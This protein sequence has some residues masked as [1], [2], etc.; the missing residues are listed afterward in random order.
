MTTT[1]TSSTDLPE[2]QK[3]HTKTWKPTTAGVL[4]IIAGALNVIVGIVLAVVG[5]AASWY[6]MGLGAAIGIPL[7]VLA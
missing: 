7:I 1:L 2:L 5:A 3:S 4:T 6:S